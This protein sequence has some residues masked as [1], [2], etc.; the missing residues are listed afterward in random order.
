MTGAD[1]LAGRSFLLRGRLLR[2]HFA[3]GAAV[4]FFPGLLRHHLFAGAFFL[5]EA[6]FLAGFFRG[7]LF[8][9]G[10]LSVPVVATGRTGHWN[11]GGGNRFVGLVVTAKRI[12]NLSALPAFIRPVFPTTRRVRHQHD[13]PDSRPP[14]KPVKPAGS[15]ILPPRHADKPSDRES[16]GSGMR[17]EV[18]AIAG[19]LWPR[20][21]G[22]PTSP[23]SRPEHRQRAALVWTEHAIGARLA[24]SARA[25]FD[26]SKGQ[27]PETRQLF[28]VSRRVID[29]LRRL[30]RPRRECEPAGS[31]P[32]EV[33]ATQRYFTEE[34]QCL[35]K[36]YFLGF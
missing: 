9:I 26:Q 2:R 7:F 4:F 24:K 23:T 1:R 18:V 33:Y 28:R 5:A 17:L 16:G 14:G 34:G 36:E 35:V 6:F 25:A 19:A 30:P 27:C 3:G 22:L 29:G 11:R 10:H 20:G 21:G 32:R 8:A 13:T 15:S 12:I 31:P